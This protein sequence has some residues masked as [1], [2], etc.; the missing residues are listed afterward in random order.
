[1]STRTNRT[2]TGRLAAIWADVTYAQRRMFELNRT[3][4]PSRRSSR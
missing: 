3:A 4:A 2:H 1:M